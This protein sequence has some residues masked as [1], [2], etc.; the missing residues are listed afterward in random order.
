MKKIMNN[1]K[2]LLSQKKTSLVATAAVALSMV[3]H[4]TMC[5]TGI[6]ALDGI[7]TLVVSVMKWAGWI[8]LAT[9]VAMIVK[10]IINSTSGQSQPGEIGKALGLAAGG[11]VL[12]AIEAVMTT[13]GVT[14]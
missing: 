10:A 13:M 5:A 14:A 11:A 12:I 2:S 7:T 6:S 9:G 8:L 1:L 3:A 4:P